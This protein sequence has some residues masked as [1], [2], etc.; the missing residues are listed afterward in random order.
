M[1]TEQR[2]QT[3]REQL[4]QYNYHYYVKDEPLI[5]D[6]DYDRLLRELQQLEEEHPALITTDS[7]TQR[8]G[9]TPLAAFEQVT[10]AMPMLSLGNVFS[11]EE[12]T[13]FDERLHE[14]LQKA[15]ISIDQIE[16]VAEPK[17]DGLAVS[18]MY[19][20]GIL[21][22]AATRG[23]GAT[24][25]NITQNIRTI[26]SIPLRLQGQ[27]TTPSRLEVRGEVIMPLAGFEA[28]NE[29][30]RKQGEKTFVNPRNA[31]A[32]S[33]RQLDARVTAA[34]PLDM[35]CYAVGICEGIDLPKTHWEILAY[36]GE[37]G[38]KLNP[39]IALACG[40][41]ACLDYYHAIGK[42]R[43]RLDYDIDGVVYKVN[44][45]DWQDILGFVSRA[46]R[47][48]T[49]HKFPAQ[50]ALSEVLS[51]EF[52]VGRTGALTPVAR[53][54][55]TFVGGVTV[56]NAT[57]HNMDEVRRKDIR[58]GDVV[59]IRRAGDVI[60][61]VVKPVLERRPD[62]VSE[63]MMPSHCPVCGSD[64]TRIEDEAVY[65][66][67]G[68]LYC[69]AQRKQAIKHFASRKAMDIDGLGDKLV[70][71]LADK[72]L[73]EHLPDLFRLSLKAVAELDRM[74]EKSAQNLLDALEKSKHTQLDRFIYALGIREVGEATAKN[75]A[76]AFGNLPDLMVASEDVLQAIP[77]VGPIVAK[78]IYEFFQQPHNREM[79]EQLMTA[80]VHWADIDVTEQ[81]QDLPLSGK[82]YVISGK[83]EQYARS[84]IKNQLEAKGAKVAGSVS[85]KT[86]ALIAGEAAGSKLTKAEELGIEVL[87]GA[88]LEALLN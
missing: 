73:V 61:E 28:I 2:I 19:E 74:A 80:G 72:G 48:A 88:D 55:P 35:Y 49:A 75:L 57:L 15:A 7:P 87:G 20:D 59:I 77:D 58:V 42:K 11:D 79:I 63:I 33:L 30:A 18:L 56:S 25:E 70:D 47:W 8:V 66:C 13:A 81:A 26:K 3:L 12:L 69:S 24:G 78:H 32:G 86:T 31:A 85:K 40:K 22:Y 14:R 76:K 71:Q 64:V 37:L 29:Q 52:Q 45:L 17:L 68:G 38:F 65:R 9:A 60:P 50:E 36:L 41:Q 43:D 39:E 21:S 16:Y 44:R 10:H 34:R 27:F 5:P 84:D 46:P 83:F 62:D 23:D 6:A 53:L 54:K 51:V 1:S 82:T 67:T 4:H